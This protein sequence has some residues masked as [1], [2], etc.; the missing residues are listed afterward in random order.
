MVVDDWKEFTQLALNFLGH[1]YLEYT[2]FVIPERKIAKAEQIDKKMLAKYPEADYDK[3][4][5]YRNKKAGQA[6]F[7][8]LR[9]RNVGVILRTEGEVKERSEA[10]KFVRLDT[11]PF[12]FAVGSTIEIKIAKAKA[13]RKYTAYLSRQSFRAIK[14]VLRD[15]IRHRRHDV[16]EDHWE[17]LKGLPAFSG[18]LGQMRELTMWIRLESKL[19]GMKKWTGS[20][21]VLRPL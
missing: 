13:G 2:H 5:R 11:E 6:N 15:N 8:Y 1:G 10:E 20:R 16:A 17:R 4:R 7:A 14:G 9:W 21:L 18:I 12:V 19:A 3:D